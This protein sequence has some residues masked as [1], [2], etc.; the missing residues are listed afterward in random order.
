MRQQT[1]TLTTIRHNHRTLNSPRCSVVDV[2][3]KHSQ[4][5]CH[6]PGATDVCGRAT[7]TAEPDAPA[8]RALSCRS[9]SSCAVRMS[10]TRRVCR[11]PHATV[12]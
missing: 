4:M 11:K 2:S 8:A 5:K 3:Q 7:A 6:S 10:C 1:P 9:M 12:S